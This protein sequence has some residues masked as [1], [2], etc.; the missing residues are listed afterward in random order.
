V[1]SSKL[2]HYLRTHRRRLGFSQKELAYL[3]ASE[4]AESRV[5]RYE[6]L[7]QEPS[8]R[9]AL[10][11]QVI[12]RVSIRELFAGMYDEVERLTLDRVRGLS[13]RLNRSD[14]PAPKHQQRRARTEA[15]LL[16]LLAELQNNN[17]EEIR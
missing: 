6:S 17:E 1:A 5:S 11:Y 10:A 8:L 2:Q 13:E 4:A 15:A 7:A 9:T 12:F 16:T 3:L 14:P